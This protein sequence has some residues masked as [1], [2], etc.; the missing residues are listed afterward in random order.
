M[1]FGKSV[2]KSFWGAKGGGGIQDKWSIPLTCISVNAPHEL[3]PSLCPKV[4]GGSN[5]PTS[6]EE[7][8]GGPKSGYKE[9]L[10]HCSLGF[11]TSLFDEARI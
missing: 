11:S 2:E 8:S 1:F 5:G 7:I 4:M 9:G 10:W 6:L 3:A